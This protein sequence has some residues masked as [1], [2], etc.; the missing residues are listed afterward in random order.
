MASKH[1]TDYESFDLTLTELDGRCSE[2]LAFTRFVSVYANDQSLPSHRATGG[3]GAALTDWAGATSP[4][5][6][7]STAQ[8][9]HIKG[10]LKKLGL[11]HGQPHIE[12]I[13]D[14]STALSTVRLQGCIGTVPFRVEVHSMACGI[15]GRDTGTFRDLTSY[16]AALFGCSVGVSFRSARDVGVEAASPAPA[17]PAPAPLSSAPSLRAVFGSSAGTAALA[18][19]PRGPAHEDASVS[20]H[21]HLH[22]HSSQRHSVGTVAVPFYRSTALVPPP[23]G[24]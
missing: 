14:T 3:V 2:P 13:M 19:P 10:L 5:V 4:Q 20:P 7:I 11:P 1:P 9:Q 8:A 15:R 24:Q 23:L 17:L 18:S 16:L 12:C 22:Q 6:H 21:P